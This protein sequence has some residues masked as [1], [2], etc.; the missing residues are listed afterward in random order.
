MATAKENS[1][2]GE[3]V[4]QLLTVEIYKR[5]QGRLVRQAT[6]GAMAAMILLGCYRLYHT[7][8]MDYSRGVKYSVLGSIL[9]VGG[10][11]IFRIV[12][13]PR[14]ANFLIAV[15]AEMVKV[16]WPNRDY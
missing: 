4:S 7:L 6:F 14:F 12:N 16:T 2:V 15:E 5:N 1:G 3:F 10:W 9:V 8:L 13:L 11:I